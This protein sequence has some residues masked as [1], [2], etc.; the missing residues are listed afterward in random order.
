M[1]SLWI[2]CVLVVDWFVHKCRWLFTSQV[3]AAIYSGKS[4]RYTSNIPRI[5]HLSTHTY[6]LHFISVLFHFS[7]VSTVPITRYYNIHKRFLIV[8]AFAPERII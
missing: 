6:F 8:S 1:R 7:P 4:V 5:I 2:G 3:L